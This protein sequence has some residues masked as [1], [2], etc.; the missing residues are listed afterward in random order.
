MSTIKIGDLVQWE[1]GAKTRVGVVKSIDGS[2]IATI[3]V[4]T[5]GGSREEKIKSERLQV[6]TSTIESE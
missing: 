1:T 5:T 3:N 4:P 2:G 6:I